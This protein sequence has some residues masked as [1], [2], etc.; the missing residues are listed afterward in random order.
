MLLQALIPALH[1]PASMAMADVLTGTGAKNLCL[2]PSGTPAT[3]GT[4]DKAPHHSLPG[5][6]ICQAVHAIGGFTP[7][8]APAIAA[9]ACADAGFDTVTPAAPPLRPARASQQP[10]APPILT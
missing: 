8:A 3:P 9:N 6:A 10:R 2:A 4:P 5:C 7:P 1:H